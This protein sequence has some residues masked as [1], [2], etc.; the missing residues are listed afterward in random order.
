MITFRVKMTILPALILM[1]ATPQGAASALRSLDVYLQCDGETRS[2]LL[3]FSAGD[4]EIENQRQAN[5]RLHIEIRNSK[6]VSVIDL[7]SGE[8]LFE[9]SQCRISTKKLACEAA[10]GNHHRQ[11]FISRTSGDAMSEGCTETSDEK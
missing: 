7:P 5:R 3:A 4:L 6:R 10:D 11:M 2:R 8:L 9:P 1:L